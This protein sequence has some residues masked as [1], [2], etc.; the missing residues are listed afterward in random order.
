MINQAHD[1]DVA[2]NLMVRE[3]ECGFRTADPVDEVSL[4]GA[5]SVHGH[6][7]GAERPIRL[8]DRLHDIEL[9]AVQFLVLGGCPELAGNASELHRVAPCFT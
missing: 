5:D 3:R 9:K 1:R 4:L 8:I 7:L 2:R 6:E